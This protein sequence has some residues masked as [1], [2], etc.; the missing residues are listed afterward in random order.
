MCGS[1]SRRLRIK[2]I[3]MEKNQPPESFGVFKPVGHIVMAFRT[4]GALQSAAGALHEQ[5]FAQAD[6]VRYTSQEMVDQVDSELRNAS[7]LASFGHELKLITTYRE[8]AA[9]GCNFLVV[10]APEAD[11]VARVA[12]VAN[13]M[14]A[15]TA[16]RYGSLII[17]EMVE[18][19]PVGAP[20][21]AP[22]AAP[23]RDDKAAAAL[24]RRA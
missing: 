14:R 24:E 16:Q 15:V 18:Q 1:Q 3:R 11:Q 7:P 20:A 12:A 13:S 8:L 2:G 5:G 23:A 9:E 19:P 4:T 21:A 10:H 6:L 17:E 22:V